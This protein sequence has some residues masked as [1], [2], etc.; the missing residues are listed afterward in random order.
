MALHLPPEFEQSMKDRLGPAFED[1]R[2]SMEQP[3][4]VCI[5]LNPKKISQC[6]G[7]TV[8][9]CNHGRYL[10]QRPAF[11]LDPLLHAGAYYV[12]EPS[13]LFLEQAVRQAVDVSKPLTVLDLCAAPGGKSTHLLSLISDESLLISNEVIRNRASILS[14]NIQKWG[15]SNVIVTQSEPPD[16]QRLPSFFDLILVDAPCSGEGLFRKDPEAMKEWS[17]RN[18][19]LCALRQRRIVTDVWTSL[20]P[21]GILIYSTCTYNEQ[22]NINNTS[23]MQSACDAESIS[24]TLK[25]DWN[26]VPVKKG[27]CF[28]YQFFPHQ[29]KGEGFFMTVFRK[30]RG[31]DFSALKTKIALRQL[32]AAQARE[33]SSWINEPDPSGFFMHHQTIRMLPS[34]NHAALQLVLNAVNVLQ[35]GTAVAEV[36]KNKMV[37]DHS[38]ALSI[39]LRKE[40]I[41]RITLDR[42]QAIAYLRKD[43]L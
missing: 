2:T 24:F 35:A 41:A 22:E 37:P 39:H 16:F 20:K 5:R 3:P 23:W 4:P 27:S 29:V 33:L 17:P 25:E 13:S 36:T 15:Y 14:E 42:L 18:V 32:S 19:E 7:D 38:L 43:P 6:D 21:G 1:F 34:R 9:W 28:G 31:G 11:T 10:P 30:K 12:Q 26:I 40:N 8:P